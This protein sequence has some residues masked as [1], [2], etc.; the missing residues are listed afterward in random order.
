[1]STFCSFSK[2]SMYSDS[3]NPSYIHPTV[4]I[5]STHD[6]LDVQH[7]SSSSAMLYELHLK[8]T[9]PPELL[10]NNQELRNGILMGCLNRTVNVLISGNKI[11]VVTGTTARDTTQCGSFSCSYA[12]THFPPF[13]LQ[14]PI[15]ILA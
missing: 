7:Q 14:F 6:L 3:F 1:M 10:L 12:H 8:A 13:F 2:T 4:Y 5:V 11:L 15:L 9:T